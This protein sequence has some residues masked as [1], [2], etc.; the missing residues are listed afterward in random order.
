MET[1]EFI[2]ETKELEAKEGRENLGLRC[3]L[4]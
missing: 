3:D 4:R 1:K 2:G